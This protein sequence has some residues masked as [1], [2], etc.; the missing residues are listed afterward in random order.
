LPEIYHR[1]ELKKGGAYIDS[2]IIK[3]YGVHAGVPSSWSA[4][5]FE[6]GTNKKRILNL[7]S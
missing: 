4:F 1:T 6:R 2:K 7:M 5:F 3:I